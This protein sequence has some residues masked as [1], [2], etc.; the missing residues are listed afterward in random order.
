MN[1]KSEI[2]QYYIIFKQ[3]PQ[4]WKSDPG[5]SCL[6][7]QHWSRKTLAIIVNIHTL[8]WIFLNFPEAVLRRKLYCIWDILLD[9]SLYSAMLPIKE[10]NLIPNF[11]AR[12]L[13]KAQS[14]IVGFFYSSIYGV[15]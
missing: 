9:I 10:A 11:S 1:K 13:L 4:F 8:D 6:D 15:V 3:G 2:F 7:S 12:P 14:D 5:Q